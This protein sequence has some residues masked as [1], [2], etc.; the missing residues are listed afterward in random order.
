MINAKEM[1]QKTADIIAN[2]EQ[3]KKDA[4]IT[5]C[6]EILSKRIEEAVEKGEYSIH[7]AI[8]P[9]RA[10]IKYITEYMNSFGYTV[11]PWRNNSFYIRWK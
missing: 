7:V 3:P 9:E 1:N 5:F 4:S 11:Q 8:Y 6:E 2:I 10:T